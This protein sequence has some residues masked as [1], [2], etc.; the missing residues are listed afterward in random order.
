MDG[1]ID[2]VVNTTLDEPVLD[3]LSRDLKSVWVK[4]K[5]VLLP[6]STSNNNGWRNAYN[7][8]SNEDTLNKL[9]DW[10]LWGPLLVC[11]LLSILLSVKAP[12]DMSST[13]FSSVFLLVWAGSATVTINAQLLGGTISF[14]QSVCV[15][16]YCIFPLAVAAMLIMLIK[17]G[18]NVLLLNIA[19]VALG[20]VWSTK[21]SVVFIGQFIV[22]EKRGLAVFPVFFFYAILAWMIII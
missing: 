4:L 16:G 7:P 1:N 6:R 20:F 14:F 12:T 18:G 13:T 15:M 8:E 9:K 5:H 17:L 21:A 22:D 19:I 3:T 2:A 10:D 11:L